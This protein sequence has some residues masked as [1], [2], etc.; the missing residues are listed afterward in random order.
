MPQL[1]A[2]LE[3]D[4]MGVA[5]EL[6]EH[7]LRFGEGAL[8]AGALDRVSGLVAEGEGSLVTLQQH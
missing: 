4:A 5:R 2:S 6:R 3:G 1:A 7:G 8:G